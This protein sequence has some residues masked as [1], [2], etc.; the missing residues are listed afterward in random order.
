MVSRT[1]KVAFKYPSKAAQLSRPGLI[2]NTSPSFYGFAG[3]RGI[4]SRIVINQSHHRY[5]HGI[6]TNCSRR[7]AVLLSVGMSLGGLLEVDK[8]YGHDISK[9]QLVGH[10][11]PANI[12]TVFTRYVSRIQE[13]IGESFNARLVIY[14]VTDRMPSGAPGDPSKQYGR[15]RKSCGQF[16]SPGIAGT[17]P[18]DICSTLS[19]VAVACCRHYAY[20]VP[21]D[22]FPAFPGDSVSAIVLSS[23]VF[24][25]PMD[26]IEGIL[27]HELGHAIDFHVFGKRYRLQN[28]SCQFLTEDVDAAL[29]KIDSSVNDA[30]YRADLFANTVLLSQEEKAL[31]YDSQSLLQTVV[32]GKDADCATAGLLNHYTH[33]PLQGRR[34]I[35][36]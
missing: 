27:A 24:K 26:T 23:R 15:D 35:V 5:E 2:L 6:K 4:K 19:S 30:E 34:K 25:L 29:H 32:H 17:Q 14:G 8:S 33:E 36:I 18:Y 28:R 20:C 31:C 16:H 3:Y 10:E 7:D 9:D 22:R 13:T 11:I 12:A 21:Y 1:T